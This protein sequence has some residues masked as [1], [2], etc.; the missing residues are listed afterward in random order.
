[1]NWIT[2]QVLATA[3]VVVVM[4]AHI[5]VISAEEREIME[6][7]QEI[8][9]IVAPDVPDAMQSR[10]VIS[11]ARIRLPADL[12]SAEPPDGVPEPVVIPIAD[13]RVVA[14]LEQSRQTTE[15]GKT[16]VIGVDNLTPHSRFVML[17]QDDVLQRGEI[18]LHNEV[19]NF[20]APE[21]DSDDNFLIFRMLTVD[22]SLLPEEREPVE[23]HLPGSDPRAGSQNIPEL[24]P[25]APVTTLVEVKL[26]VV[27]TPAAK[28]ASESL[29]GE[30]IEDTI[31]FSVFLANIGYEY[32][33][34][35][36]LNLVHTQ[37]VSYTETGDLAKDIDRLACP[38][39]HLIEGVGNNHL[40]EVFVPW[41]AY[42][43]DIVSLWV[44]TPSE[45]G[46]ANIMSTVSTD[47]A[48]L[49]VNVVHW[50]AATLG[51]TFD[52]EIGHNF[53]ARHDRKQD[54]NDGMPYNHNHGFVN[55][56]Q[57][58]VTI[59]AYPSS[60][61][62]LG[63]SCSRSTNWSDPNLLPVNTWGLAIGPL[64]ADNARALELSVPTIASL[65][66]KHNLVGCCVKT[67]TFW[68]TKWKPG[69][70]P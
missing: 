13:D 11:V 30:S 10:G 63:F 59:M 66:L 7:Y 12:F 25:P 70:C 26:M 54:P 18:R 15:D 38:C 36:T 2:S 23:H 55:V 40:N 9:L 41:K 20:T 43:A 60:C 32:Q 16:Y 8:E 42:Q 22:P 27:Y 49:A 33:A 53:G 4:G 34:G 29:W 64:A 39:D 1:M 50:G 46:I 56:A 24:P 19:I 48:P 51:L 6:G 3:L 61:S 28:A 17:L 65:E 52:H 69:P 45:A 57:E 37:Q 44:H 35:V 58:Q 47:F 68:H 21:L 14:L 31:D 62:P 5:G 67:G